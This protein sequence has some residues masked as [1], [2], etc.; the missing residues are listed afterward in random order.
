MKHPRYFLNLTLAATL[1][2]GAAPGLLADEIRPSTAPN[3]TQKALIDRGYGMFIH[4][5]MNTFLEQE[6]SDGTAPASTYAP[7]AL[8]PEQWVRTAAD[9]GFR[10]VVLTAKHHDGFC[11]W[12]SK[13]TD[14]DVASSP[15]KTDVVGAVADACRK[16]GLKFGLYYS[17]WDRHDPSYT[18]GDFGKY[19]DYMEGQL[20]ELLSG[21]GDVCEL[22][23][24]GGWDKPAADWQIDRLYRTV[25]RLQ[26][27]CAFGVNNAMMTD[28][29][30]DRGGFDNMASPDD[31]VEGRELFLRYFPNDF[32]L[33][34]PKIA[35]RNDR[36]VYTVSGQDYYLPFEHTICLS[37]KWTWFQ[38]KQPSEVR[39][40]EELQ[41]LFYWCTA[42][43]NVLVINVPPD[44]RGL[45]REN[46][47][48]AVISL[49]KR[50]G[51][52]REKPLPRPGR[53]ISADAPATATSTWHG[54][55]A[56]SPSMAT[57]GGM[58]SRWASEELTPKLEIALSPADRFNKITIFEYLDDVRGADYFTST[59]ANRIRRYSIDIAT[60]DG[61]WES[62]YV[63][64]EPMGDCKVIEFPRHYSTGRVRLNVLDASDHPS[65]H[66]ILFTDTDEQ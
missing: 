57:D 23:L 3:L 41:E 58:L 65:I 66:E 51:I 52:D 1:A 36:K 64:D 28:G 32:R 29:G 27:L 35:R 53:L 33:A 2:M 10:Y 7:T 45:I 21:Y 8:D 61:D 9:A 39:S 55:A 47:A 19:I 62:I 56:Y 43:D 12:D 16:Y 49:G 4:F 40:P 48:N 54:E 5:G 15:V 37:K 22:W 25:H 20:T 63:S 26:P 44:T 11:L 13:L 60:P 18:S 34:D 17:L 6:W 46:E 14:Y 59:R 31:M 50:L 42:N 30:D 38:K 24:D